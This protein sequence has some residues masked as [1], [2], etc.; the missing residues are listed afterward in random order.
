MAAYD[1]HLVRPPGRPLTA[2]D[3]EPLDLLTWRETGRDAGAVEGALMA[4]R[5]LA[6]T[7]DALAGGREVFMPDRALQP[8]PGAP[9][10]QLWD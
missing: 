8:Q 4:N 3:D 9:L 1:P 6:R 5:G 7:A 2:H 10:V